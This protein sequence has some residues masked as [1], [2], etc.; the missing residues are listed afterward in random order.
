MNRSRRSPP[1][2][3]GLGHDPFADPQLER[4]PFFDALDEAPR[5]GAAEAAASEEASGGG[6]PATPNPA[7]TPALPSLKQLVAG[8]GLQR[9]L[10]A[11]DRER[12]ET[13]APPRGEGDRFGFDPESLADTLPGLL[14]LYR[15]WFRVESRGQA[16][17]PRDGRAIL[18]SNH[19]GLLP[20]DGAMILTDLLLKSDPPRLCRAL[21]DRRVGELDT[22]REFFEA[23]GQVPGT[24]TAF[25]NLLDAGATVLVFPEGTG[26]ACK[27]YSERYRLQPFHS[28]F[29]QEA[30]RTGTPIV[31]MAVIGSD[32]QAPLLFDWKSLANRF[33]LPALPIT[34]TFPWLGLLGLLPL[35]VRYRIVYSEPIETSGRP[36]S[37]AAK[38]PERV[39]SI[40]SEVRARIQGL[41]DARGEAFEAGPG[42]SD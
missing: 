14:F 19:A 29:A 41:L 26:G 9:F 23:I 13:L 7:A 16:R 32:D 11:E 22:L 33:G 36:D 15:S 30:L 38:D 10:A 28:G 37:Q 8:L 18:V 40:V 5:A 12:V 39:A 20:F 6:E 34:P 21:V 27:P 3:S 35:P 42:T 24:R 25:R 17:L 2:R 31:P 4:D 1:S